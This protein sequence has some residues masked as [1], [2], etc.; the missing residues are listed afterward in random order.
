MLTSPKGSRY[1]SF[2]NELASFR[3]FPF[4]LTVRA[5]TVSPARVCSI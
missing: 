2:P 3:P 1:R 4:Y 5:L